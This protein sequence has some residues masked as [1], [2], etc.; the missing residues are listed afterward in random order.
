MEN[1]RNHDT[2]LT[3]SYK[4]CS[5]LIAFFRNSPDAVIWDITAAFI[6]DLLTRAFHPKMGEWG[7]RQGGTKNEK[8]R[9]E[10]EQHHLNNQM[11]IF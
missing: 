3:T 8:N 6:M 11:K 1:V 4:M 9:K 10:N 7:A 5:V 2:F